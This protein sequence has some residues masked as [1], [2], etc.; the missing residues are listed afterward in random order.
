MI[1]NF[2]KYR[3]EIYKKNCENPKEIGLI[4]TISFYASNDTKAY[5]TALKFTEQL[6]SDLKIGPEEKLSMS[7]SEIN[8]YRHYDNLQ[9]TIR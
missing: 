4:A 1:K 6:K 8:F 5:Q 2:K 3:F 9:E 7:A